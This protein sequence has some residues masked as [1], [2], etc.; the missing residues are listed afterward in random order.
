MLQSTNLCLK[1]IGRLQQLNDFCASAEMKGTK[2]QEDGK[3]SCDIC[4]FAF[5]A[6]EIVPETT[7][8]DL[9]FD[10]ITHINWIKVIRKV[11]FNLKS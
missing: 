5:S 7:Q 10:K 8:V 4:C 6:F 9:I 2:E 3:S 11:F 1:C